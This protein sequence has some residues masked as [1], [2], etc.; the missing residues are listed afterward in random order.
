MYLDVLLVDGARVV[1][2]LRLRLEDDGLERPYLLGL[3][4]CLTPPDMKLTSN[5]KL[6]TKK[7]I[8]NQPLL[9]VTEAGASS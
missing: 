1:G 8:Q 2:L 5:I 4:N 9:Y 3:G 7:K 6:K